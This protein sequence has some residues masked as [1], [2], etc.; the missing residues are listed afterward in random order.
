MNEIE[1][2]SQR[3]RVETTDH[4]RR[5]ERSAFVSRYV[6]GGLS[7]EDHAHHLRTLFE[8][9]SALEA[10]LDRHREDPHVGSF[11]LPELWRT[12]AV[13]RDLEFLMGPTWRQAEPVPAS[14][15]YR[16]RVEHLASAGSTRLI[17]HAYV[18]YM[19]DL[20]GGRVLERLTAKALELGEHGL[21]FLAFPGVSDVE[22]FKHGFRRRLDELDVDD[23]QR[24]GIVDEAM[25]AFV[26]NESMFDD[27]ERRSGS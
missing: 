24:Q 23:G 8:V 18:R 21:E 15:T 14:R 5:A 7:R 19:G 20:S 27:L 10:G 12:E 11:F 6:R 1:T 22:S 17:A 3:L 13:E 16:E 9:Y 25:R 4:H 26:L 2:L